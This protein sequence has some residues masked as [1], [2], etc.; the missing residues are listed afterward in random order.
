[1]IA[2]WQIGSVASLKCL[3]ASSLETLQV[4][5]SG[6]TPSR[7]IGALSRTGTALWSEALA[8]AR[9]G[10]RQPPV[11]RTRNQLEEFEP[12]PRVFT[13]S[14]T[15]V[16]HSAAST[17]PTDRPLRLLKRRIGSGG[18]VSVRKGAGLA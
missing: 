11:L 14:P 12:A 16:P 8:P 3:S 6:G 9:A 1:M 13:R 18:A 17:Q 10:H 5:E 15:C 4:F 2:A 7:V